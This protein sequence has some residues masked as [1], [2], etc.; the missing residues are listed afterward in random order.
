ME[1][2]ETAFCPELQQTLS[3]QVV[4]GASLPPCFHWMI[5][6]VEAIISE[7]DT[8]FHFNIQYSDTKA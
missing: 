8:G 6:N 2:K 1:A 3:T 4:D 5:R 7:W